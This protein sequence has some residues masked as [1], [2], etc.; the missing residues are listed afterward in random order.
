MVQSQHILVHSRSTGI[1][2]SHV[3]EDTPA[4]SA[5]PDIEQ[6][7]RMKNGDSEFVSFNIDASK[8]LE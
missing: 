8:K 2:P 5:F 4:K 7:H 3:A 1:V 6:L